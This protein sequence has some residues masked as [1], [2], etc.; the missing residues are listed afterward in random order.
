M[1]LNKEDIESEKD[2]YRQYCSNPTILAKEVSKRIDQGLTH[3]LQDD[4][5]S[6]SLE[7]ILRQ[8]LMAIKVI[9]R[10]IPQSNAGEINTK[11]E[12]IINQLKWIDLCPQL[13]ANLKSALLSCNR[14]INPTTA[15]TLI[16][17]PLYKDLKKQ[18][19]H[20]VTP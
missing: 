12:W 5:A 18:I 17:S 11:M 4:K 13:L 19:H 2:V 3:L 1:T 16:G 8:R 10:S 14:G 7:T 9:N 20:L 15:S 6:A